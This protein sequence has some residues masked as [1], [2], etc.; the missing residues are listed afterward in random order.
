MQAKSIRSR[1]EKAQ[2]SPGCS[3]ECLRALSESEEARSLWILNLSCVNPELVQCSEQATDIYARAKTKLRSMTHRQ[4][5]GIQGILI[6]LGMADYHAIS[7]AREV[8][9]L[10]QDLANRKCL[11]ILS[12][13]EA[14]ADH[15]LAGLAPS[16]QSILSHLSSG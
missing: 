11:G 2:L 5:M 1:E 14:L 10:Q 13:A 8:T 3:S 6:K 4:Q 12:K 9:G 16:A 15:I 7:L